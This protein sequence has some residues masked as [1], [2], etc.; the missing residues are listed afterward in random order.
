MIAINYFAT[1]SCNCSIET[2]HTVKGDFISNNDVLRLQDNYYIKQ[3]KYQNIKLSPDCFSETGDLIDIF[4]SKRNNKDIKINNIPNNYHN[5]IQMILNILNIPRCIIYVYNIIEFSNP[6]EMRQSI[7]VKTGN[8]GFI[9]DK[10]NAD[11]YWAIEHV[12]KI[13]ITRK[14]NVQDINSI[15][16]KIFTINVEEFITPKIKKSK[17]ERY[18]GDDWVAASKTRN[19]S[20]NDHCLDYFRAFN[21]K[22]ISDKPEKMRNSFELSSKYERS[23]KDPIDASSFVDFLLISGNTFEDKIINDII[24][25]FKL[26]IF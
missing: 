3:S 22:K 13:I 18:I 23:N 11:I 25:T 16:D 6:R 20:L 9:T 1:I 2:T 26:I 4:I 7:K 21:V 17:K 10:E 8:Y 15:N 5:Y 19:S 12:N 14:R 24:Y